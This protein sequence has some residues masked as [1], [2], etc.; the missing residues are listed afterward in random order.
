M[1]INSNVLGKNILKFLLAFIVLTFNFGS[2]S[3]FTKEVFASTGDE[4]GDGILDSKQKIF[5]VEFKLTKD[6][7][8]FGDTNLSNKRSVKYIVSG[9]EGSQN[10]RELDITTARISDENGNEIKPLGVVKDFDIPIVNK[11]GSATFD[12]DG[13][14]NESGTKYL[15]EQIQKLKLTRNMVFETKTYEESFITFAGGVTESKADGIR[16]GKPV[17][18][19][20]VNNALAEFNKKGYRISGWRMNGVGTIYSHLQVAN[21]IV[22]GPVKFVAVYVRA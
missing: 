11:G 22:L 10:D 8:T 20:A 3:S 1:K 5:T 13:E 18:N 9:A 15:V 17:G 19:V 14:W 7:L 6:E 12:F 21:Y 2:V 4:N 16:I